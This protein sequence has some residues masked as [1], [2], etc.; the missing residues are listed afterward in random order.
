MSDNPNLLGS[1]KAVIAATIDPDVLTATTHDSDWVDMGLFEQI[2]AIIMV[3]TLGSSATVDAILQQATD[4]SGTGVKAITGKAI[5]QLTDAGSDSDKQAVINCRSEEL[6][7]ANAFTHVRLR[8]T[9]A[10]ASSD[11]A[12]LILGHSARYQIPADLA[13]V[14][15]IV[16]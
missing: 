11:G 13:S 10:T 9:V 3:G 6:D 15:E 8:I 14:D 16:E 7:V 5:T 4:S 2:Q 1:Q 12:G